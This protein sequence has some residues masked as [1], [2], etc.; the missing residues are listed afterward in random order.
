MTDS[1]RKLISHLLKYGKDYKYNMEK[2][3]DISGLTIQKKMESFEEDGFVSEERVVVNRKTRYYYS[4]NFPELLPL[5]KNLILEYWGVQAYVKGKITF[6]IGL[7]IKDITKAGKKIEQFASDYLNMIELT[8]RTISPRVEEVVG[9]LQKTIVELEEDEAT[10]LNKVVECAKHSSSLRRL[11][12]MIRT[13]HS[14]HE[15]KY[16]K[17]KVKEML[18]KRLKNIKGRLHIAYEKIL[19]IIEKELKNRQTRNFQDLKR[20]YPKIINI[21]DTKRIIERL[22]Q[23]QKVLIEKGYEKGFLTLT[24]EERIDISLMLE[25]NLPILVSWIWNYIDVSHTQISVKKRF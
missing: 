19:D 24:E 17:D 15:I 12:T 1:T 21:M 3:L 10:Y 23:K 5:Y 8:E 18:F 20:S 14:F 4:I 7:G 6:L 25:K 2:Q 13:A 22:S 11:D 9:E 16:G